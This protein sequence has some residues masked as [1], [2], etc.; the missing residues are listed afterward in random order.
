MC[1]ELT[2][3]DDCSV[4]STS[5]WTACISELMRMDQRGF[6]LPVSLI[7]QLDISLHQQCMCLCLSTCL[8]ICLSV[9]Q[10]LTSAVLAAAA[11]VQLIVTRS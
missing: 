5:D 11:A 8:F 1:D 4:H 3:V 6:C 10:V 9:P 2:G 7:H